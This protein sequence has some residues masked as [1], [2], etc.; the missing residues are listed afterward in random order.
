METHIKVNLLE[1]KRKGQVL[2]NLMLPK[3]NMKVNL[4]MIKNKEKENITSESM[5]TMKETLM[6]KKI[7]QE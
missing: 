4:V 5:V 7:Y 1:I 3:L 2:Y 6:N